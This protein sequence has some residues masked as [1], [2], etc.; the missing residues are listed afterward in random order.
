M[1]LLTSEYVLGL[2]MPFATWCESGGLA[3][4]A[5]RCEVASELLAGLVC[6]LADLGDFQVSLQ[7]QLEP[8]NM[9]P[10][11]W[12]CHFSL[13]SLVIGGLEYSSDCAEA[14][15]LDLFQELSN[16]LLFG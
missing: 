1:S 7:L 5:G 8:C 9:G 6:L 2:S 12:D 13:Q 4:L 11:R 16:P 3:E 10:Q 15:L 14:L